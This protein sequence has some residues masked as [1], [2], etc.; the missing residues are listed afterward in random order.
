MQDFA[1]NV[2]TL[3]SNE[4]RHTLKLSKCPRLLDLLLGHAGVFNHR[5]FPLL[6]V[7]YLPFV[8]VPV[9]IFETNLFCLVA[10]NAAVVA[11]I[12]RA[13]DPHSCFADPDTAVFL[14]ADSDLAAF[15]MR[16]RIQ[17]KNS[18]TFFV[19]KSTGIL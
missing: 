16:I 8:K 5:K 7:V 2:A 9:P 14:N 13:V 15:L 10:L 12:T 4:G 1:I 17:L 6:P 11:G 19:K 3:L 18:V